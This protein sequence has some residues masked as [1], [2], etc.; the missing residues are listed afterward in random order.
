MPKDSGSPSNEQTS[1]PLA[2]PAPATL[3]QVAD[4]IG[5]HSHGQRTALIEA[6]IAE[7]RATTKKVGPVGFEPTL[8]GS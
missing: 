3:S 6:L 4:I 5:S 7:T 8:A 1:D 2:A